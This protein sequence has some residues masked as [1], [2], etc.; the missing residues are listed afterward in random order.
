MNWKCGINQTNSF[1]L[2][3]QL[4]FMTA[5]VILFLLQ[6]FM[7]NGLKIYQKEIFN[8]I[9]FKIS[10]KKSKKNLKRGL[11]KKEEPSIKEKMEILYEKVLDALLI[12]QEKLT[13]TEW[14]KL[15]VTLFNYIFP[16]TKTVLDKFTIEQLKEIKNKE[17][18]IEIQILPNNI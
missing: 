1:F 14:V 5:W 12:N 15:F 6:N 7:K 4:I 8:Y 13:K 18:W 16:K 17:L 2:D 11:A 10:K 9:L 3:L